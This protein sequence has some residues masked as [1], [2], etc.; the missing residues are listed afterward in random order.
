MTESRA[1]DNG[2]AF[3]RSSPYV[4]VS[5]LLIRPCMS[6]RFAVY[7]RQNG[8][9]VLYTSK[10]QA[11]STEH[12]EKL[13]DLGVA[14]VFIRKEHLGEYESYLRDNLA[15]ILGDAAIP[16]DVKSKAWLHASVTLLKTIFSEKL[17]KPLY[18]AKFTQVTKLVKDSIALFEQGDSLSSVTRLIARGYKDYAHSLGVMSLSY[19][20]LN[21]LDNIGQETLVNASIGAILHDI[22]K[23]AIPLA[24]R[25][26]NPDY[27]NPFEAELYRS[28]PSVG[29]GLCVNLPLPLEAYHCILFHHEQDNGQGYPSGLTGDM[30]PVYVKAISLCNMYDSLTRVASYRPAH[31]PFEALQRIA[32]WR[33]AFNRDM[34]RRLV[35]VLSNAAIV[36]KDAIALGGD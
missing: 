21:T 29:V 25:E 9:F 19:F 14:W 18:K 23:Q 31:T 11:Y 35:S 32:A 26:K 6:G 20:V 8:K 16:L 3:D 2:A 1:D 28:H 27:R 24:I 12:R 22:G 30:S 15:E 4:P 17:P 34:F 10:G 13:D 5:P 7:L 33:D 36:K